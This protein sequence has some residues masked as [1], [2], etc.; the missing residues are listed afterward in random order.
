MNAFEAHWGVA[1]TEILEK[2]L[3]YQQAGQVTL[4]WDPW[5]H[6][7]IYHEKYTWAMKKRS[8]C[9]GYVGIYSTQVSGDDTYKPL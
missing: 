1:D 9:L 3:I 7:Y 5:D 2:T 6:S 4:V 8:G